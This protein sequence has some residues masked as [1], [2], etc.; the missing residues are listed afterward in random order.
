MSKA[1]DCDICVI[2]GGAAGLSTASG[3]SQLGLKVVLI[4]KAAMGGEC[5]NNGCVPSKALL[6]KASEIRGYQAQSWSDVHTRIQ[7]SIQAIAPHD[8]QERFESLGVTVLRDHACFTSPTTIQVGEA[9]LRPRFT[10]IAVGGKPFVPDIKISDE[11]TVL[12]NENIFEIS[13]VPGHL[14]IVGAGAI[15]ME[16]ATAFADLGTKVTLVN[17]TRIVGPYSEKTSC[18]MAAQ[19]GAQGVDVIENRQVKALNATEAILDDGR[20]IPMDACLIAAGRVHDFSS[21]GLDKAGVACGK[22]GITVNKALQTSNKRIYAIGDCA[23]LPRRTTHAAG[24]EAGLLVRKIG[25]RLPIKHDA[26][27]IPSV[28]YA[29]PQLAASGISMDEAAKRPNLQ[30]LEDRF[31]H[32]DRAVCEGDT[33]GHILVA[34][35]KKGRVHGV[36]I[37]GRQAADLLPVWQM[38]ITHRLRLSKLAG[39]IHPYPTRGELSKKLAGSFYAPRLFSPMMRRI[40]RAM[41]ALT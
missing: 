2:G 6:S 15:G 5:L 28:I 35:D 16:M 21:L 31:D 34:V 20:K 3:L 37:C 8:S 39:T 25:L 33:E 13:K 29:R 14:V 40:V 38:M 18:V 4:E 9:V 27:L 12:T 7:D 30:V 26:D 10:V 22:G 1:F 19:L 41:H 17:R 36:E 24:Y 11:A 32:N 23:D